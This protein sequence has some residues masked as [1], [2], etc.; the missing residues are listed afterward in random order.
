MDQLEPS[1]PPELEREVFKIAAW[2]YPSTIPAL[3]L[4][5]KRVF[6]WTEALLFHT[7]AATDEAQIL[8]LKTKSLEILRT[9][10]RNLCLD[11]GPSQWSQS[12]ILTTLETCVQVRRIAL[13]SMYCGPQILP[14]LSQ[15]RLDHLA[16]CLHALFGGHDLPYWD[17]DSA[18]FAT[19][20]HLDISD[21]I[22]VCSAASSTCGSHLV[23]H[24]V[25]LPSLTHLRLPGILPDDIAECFRTWSQLQVLLI[26]HSNSIRRRI[27]LA[28]WL[29]QSCLYD[30]SRVVLVVRASGR[31]DWEDGTRGLRDQWA[32]ADELV[33]HRTK[34][35]IEWKRFCLDFIG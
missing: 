27:R 33:A 35:K 23:Q 11:D 16:V 5:S 19:V 18:L 9:S 4:V 17:V 22:N 30:D 3:L 32:R 14:Y 15:M 1:L 2:T 10:I 21:D 29:R 13:G 6:A 24:L 20:T 26:S 8:A 7:V 28:R 25:A 12:E 34:W 31:N